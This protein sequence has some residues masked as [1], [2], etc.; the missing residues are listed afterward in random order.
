M[1]PSDYLYLYLHTYMLIEP[2][3]MDTINMWVAKIIMKIENTTRKFRSRSSA[4]AH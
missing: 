2:R 3:M 1:N 4:A